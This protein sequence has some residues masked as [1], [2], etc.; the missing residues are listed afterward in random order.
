MMGRGA[1]GQLRH[2]MSATLPSR[3]AFIGIKSFQGRPREIHVGLLFSA[4]LVA[5]AVRVL[6]FPWPDGGPLEL[7]SFLSLLLLIYLFPPAK[8][9]GSPRAHSPATPSNL[10]GRK[11]GLKSRATQILALRFGWVVLVI[12]YEVSKPARTRPVELI[13]GAA[14]WRSEYCI[15]SAMSSNQPAISAS[16]ARLAS[17]LLAMLQCS[18]LPGAFFF[19]PSASSSSDAPGGI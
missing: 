7:G 8:M 12:W 5:L 11:T 1:S 15:L 18:M 19:W 4:H 9:L 14:G 13:H 17:Q 10:R 6:R 2:P 16:I 3:T